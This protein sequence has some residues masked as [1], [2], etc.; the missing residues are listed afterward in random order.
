MAEIFRDA[1]RRSSETPSTVSLM[2]VGNLLSAKKR[3]KEGG[4]RSSS[5]TPPSTPT[6]SS[7]VPDDSDSFASCAHCRLK[8][9]ESYVICRLLFLYERLFVQYEKTN[10]PE[11]IRAS[12]E[13]HM[14]ESSKASSSVSRKKS[15]SS[16]KSSNSQSKFESDGEKE[17]WGWY[18]TDCLQQKGPELIG[19]KVLVWWP[20]DSELYQGVIN[21][22]DEASKR[23]RV[24]YE[25]NEWE[26]IAVDVEPLL[27]CPRS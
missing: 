21:A 25:D 19:W 24:L 17:T 7:P 4:R 26:F 22:Y 13:E 20:D 15:K 1:L 8:V 18:C 10:W 9:S 14:S 23:H 12:F 5:R 3:D 16:K 27:F 11:G 6:V 2:Q